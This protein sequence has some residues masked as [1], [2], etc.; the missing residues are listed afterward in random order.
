MSDIPTI[1]LAFARA[2]EVV[3]DFAPVIAGT[4]GD[5]KDALRASNRLSEFAQDPQAQADAQANLGL[6][7]V[8]PLAYYILAKA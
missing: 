4:P 7:A 3:A 1:K 5:A 2:P 6:G 8:D